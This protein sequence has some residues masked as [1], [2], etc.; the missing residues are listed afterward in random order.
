MSEPQSLL[1][2][3]SHPQK[4]AGERTQLEK[5]HMVILPASLLLWAEGYMNPRVL[6]ET[7]LDFQ[8]SLGAD[9]MLPSPRTPHPWTIILGSV[10]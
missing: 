6:G 7:S 2:S 4:G 9:W 5:P 1:S 10:I 3:I 8:L